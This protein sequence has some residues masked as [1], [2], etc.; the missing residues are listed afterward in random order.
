MNFEGNLFGFDEEFVLDQ[1]SD[2]EEY[3]FFYSYG[4]EVSFY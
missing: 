4:E 1:N 2:E 3:Y